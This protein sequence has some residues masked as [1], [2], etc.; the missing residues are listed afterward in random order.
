[1]SVK[2]TNI[3]ALKSG[4]WYTI[5]NLLSKSIV[6]LTTPI[7]T[8]LLTQ[9]EFGSFN[10]YLSW[11]ALLMILITLNLDSTLISARY[12][13][14]EKFDSYILSLL[15]LS[16]ISG[17]IWLVIINLN[18]SFFQSFFDLPILYINIMLI[19]LLFYP[20]MTLFQAR[21]QY[22]Y[23]YKKNIAVS[24]F[25]SIG[26]ALVSVLLVYYLSNKLL[27]RIVGS[28]I[29]TI[30]VGLFS[31]IYFILKGKTIKLS[32]WKYALPICLP[33]IPHLL[34]MTVLNSMDRVMINK[35]CGSEQT[36]LYSLAYTCGT[37]MIVLLTSLNNAFAPWLA[38]KLNEKKYN[39]IRNFSYK[40]ISMFVL[41]MIGVMLVS[42]EILYILGGK[43]YMESVYVL[44]PV[45][46]GCCCQFLYTMYVNIEQFNRKTIGMAIGSA[47]AAI[48]NFVLNL[49]FIP[50][51]GYI[52]AA[53]TTLVGFLFLVIIHM[54]LV[55]RL[56]FGKV[57]NNRFVVTVIVIC[58]IC[59]MIVTRLYSHIYIRYF[60]V[61]L[62]SAMLLYIF[63]KNKDELISLK[64]G[65]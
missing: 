14:K 50:K 58:L 42:P 26:T 49:M 36:A 55:K 64:R 10:N 5:S 15:V 46:M 18:K 27:G 30:I 47:C 28:V 4:L 2:T 7:F 23:E 57:Y 8:R 52:A 13:F 56:G 59:M 17:V 34:S 41:M 11:T 31:F 51:F 20:G 43:S 48:L 45:T 33:Y 3:R 61:L 1:M 44:A 19:Y 37:L 62:Y 25:I 6:F 63:K 38:D 29:P 22:L 16:T 21:E 65:E 40:Y 39:E 60:V 12:A 35:F 53:Y 9:E 54:Y 32:Y 24:M